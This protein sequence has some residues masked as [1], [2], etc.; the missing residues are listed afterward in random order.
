MRNTRG[1]VFMIDYQ[2]YRNIGTKIIAVRNRVKKPFWGEAKRERKKVGLR[3]TFNTN[4]TNGR[5]F[6]TLSIAA[7]NEVKTTKE[8]CRELFATIDF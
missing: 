2:W 5:C 4:L 7:W 1:R 8:L 3:Q 6:Y